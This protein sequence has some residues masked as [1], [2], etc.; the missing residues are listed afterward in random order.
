MCEQ[1]LTLLG[2]VFLFLIV[3]TELLMIEK[4]QEIEEGNKI[5][6]SSGTKCEN[7]S[8][9]KA[10]ITT[11]KLSIPSLSVLAAGNIT[12]PFTRFC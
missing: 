1:T 6:I 3:Q 4:E 11:G 8:D 2:T 10:W 9:N 12:D 5:E 7:E